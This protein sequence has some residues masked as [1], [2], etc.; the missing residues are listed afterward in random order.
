MFGGVTAICGVMG[1]LAGG[2]V[3]D[4]MTS[5]LPNAFKVILYTLYITRVNHSI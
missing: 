5:T 3:L 1:S 2:L 4:R